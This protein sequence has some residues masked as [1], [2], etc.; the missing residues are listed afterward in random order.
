MNPRLTMGEINNTHQGILKSRLKRLNRISLRSLY[1]TILFVKQKI[2]KKDFLSQKLYKIFNLVL[3]QIN[4]FFYIN[5]I[6]TGKILCVIVLQEFE[7]LLSY[8][9]N[10]DAEIHI[11]IMFKRLTFNCLSI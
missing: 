4:K 5:I 10:I 6:L 9:H 1:R 7:R 11:N 2:D 8:I 3:L